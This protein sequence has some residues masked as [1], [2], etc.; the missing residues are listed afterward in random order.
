MMIMMMM[1]RRRRG[2]LYMFDTWFGPLQ[3]QAI[4]DLHVVFPAIG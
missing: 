4:P 3:P 1:R 2:N